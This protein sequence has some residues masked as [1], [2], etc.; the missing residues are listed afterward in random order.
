M[1]DEQLA[2]TQKL[3]QNQLEQANKDGNNYPNDK[4]CTE[5]I[6]IKEPNDKTVAT[7]QMVG[8]TKTQ[9]QHAQPAKPLQE[10]T[11]HNKTFTIDDL[12]NT[13]I[14]LGHEFYVDTL[15]NVFY[16]LQT[17]LTNELANKANKTG[18]TAVISFLVGD[19]LYTGSLGDSSA[20]LLRQD[21]IQQLNIRH[22]PDEKYNSSEVERIQK[23]GGAVTVEDKYS[24]RLKF[25]ATDKE[26][27]AVSRAFGDNA[28]VESGLIHIPD[29]TCVKIESGCKLVQCTDGVT[30]Y[31]P[32]SK[33]QELTNQ[34]GQTIQDAAVNIAKEVAQCG[35]HD[36]TTIQVMNLEPLASGQMQLFCVFDGHGGDAVSQYLAKNVSFVFEETLKEQVEHVE[37]NKKYNAILSKKNADSSRDL[38]QDVKESQDEF[39]HL[40]AKLF[41]QD[42]EFAATLTADNLESHD[43]LREKLKSSN[44]SGFENNL[45]EKNKFWEARY[46]NLSEKYKPAVKKHIYSIKKLAEDIKQY[47]E[48]NNAKTDPELL[49]LQVEHKKIKERT[50]KLT[51]EEVVLNKTF[52]LSGAFIPMDVNKLPEI[53]FAPARKTT[54][55]PAG[56]ALADEATRIQE[57]TIDGKIYTKNEFIS[58]FKD[59]NLTPLAERNT[60]LSNFFKSKNFT[61]T[62]FIDY[63]DQCIVTAATPYLVSATG[64]KQA[65]SGTDNLEP[66]IAK[67]H[68]Y[69]INNEIY[70]IGE[71]DGFKLSDGRDLPGK[72]FTV[73]KFNN[74]E[75]KKGFE[76]VGLSVTTTLLA[77]LINPKTSNPQTVS[78]SEI[79]EAKRE[80][81]YAELVRALSLL[82]AKVTPGVTDC[83]ILQ[84]YYKIIDI[85][86]AH[87][88]IADFQLLTK[89]ALAVVAAQ[90][91]LTDGGV[92]PDFSHYLS[93]LSEVHDKYDSF[94]FSLLIGFLFIAGVLSILTGAGILP[95]LGVLG[96][97]AEPLLA[98]AT[99][100]FI[101]GGSSVVGSVV[102]YA[103]KEKSKTLAETQLSEAAATTPVPKNK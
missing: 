56:Y 86:N 20:F 47:Q 55:D 36:N 60:V 43:K 94:F 53:D 90:E 98:T 89:V 5:E 99:E 62:A 77:R 19:E 66:K 42:P 84:I 1:I 28:L 33:I 64:G 51:Q 63:Y 6:T 11:Y 25:G 75:D 49:A 21:Q 15:N 50:S 17:G 80:A 46:R 71:A 23:A 67:L 82:K 88:D 44:S 7:I 14:K 81:A 85:K 9:S 72:T 76:W 38:Y 92:Q 27:I 52:E 87:F 37:N 61:D 12:T 4:P 45:S 73:Y 69:N 74:Q 41:Q 83:L 57:I 24:N 103:Y 58:K 3:A 18:A 29:I 91:V 8:K 68:F 39:Y 13:E 31:L 48:N 22:N 2:A 97:I 30:D 101:A 78:N 35:A 32:P 59:K 102:A 16:K 65:L 79:E 70:C 40:F 10:D 100:A 54:K 34:N 93:L 95:G 26:S 96:L